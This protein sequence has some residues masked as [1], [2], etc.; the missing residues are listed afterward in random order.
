MILVWLVALPVVAYL[1]HVHVYFMLSAC[2]V[3]YLSY[4][5]HLSQVLVCFML[6]AFY[7]DE[8]NRGLVEESAQHGDLLFLQATCK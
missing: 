2:H 5:S 1:S 3:S 4:L 6:S 7:P 8:I